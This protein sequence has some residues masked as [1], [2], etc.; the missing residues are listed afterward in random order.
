MTCLAGLDSGL[1]CK[2]GELR[3]N[4]GAFAADIALFATTPRGLQ[5]LANELE[6][7]LALY[8]LSISSGPQGKLPS[9]RLD[10]DGKAKKWVVDP[11]PY[12]R[13]TGETLPAVS[14]SQVY[15]YLGA[16]ISPQRTKANVEELE[17]C[18]LGLA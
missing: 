6:S 5:T 4:H 10:I 18:R 12:L 8:G 13:I 14:V 3:V 7:Q 16:D 2:V 15:R 1:G 9:L 11:H 17:G